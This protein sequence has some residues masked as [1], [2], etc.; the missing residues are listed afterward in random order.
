MSVLGEPSAAASSN[1]KDETRVAAGLK[2]TL[3]N[4]RVSDEAKER[5][6]ERLERFEQGHGTTDMPHAQGDD[7]IL[8]SSGPVAADSIPI[9]KRPGLEDDE[10][11]LPDILED[12]DT[13]DRREHREAGGY[14]A[15]LRNDRTSSAAKH[16]AQEQLDILET[17]EDV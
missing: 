16:R 15:A 5:A 1:Y 11:Y 12:E 4:P 7:N 2:A 3:K 10:T 6:A 8:D 9:E 13:A 17:S 14:K